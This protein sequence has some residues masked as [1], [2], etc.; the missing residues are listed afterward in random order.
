MVAV[1]A[2]TTPLFCNQKDAFRWW[3]LMIKILDRKFESVAGQFFNLIYC[4]LRFPYGIQF[5]KICNRSISH[6]PVRI[7]HTF[8]AKYAIE[9]LAPEGE[10]DYSAPVFQI[11][12][13]PVHRRCSGVERL[14]QSTLIPRVWQ[15]MERLKI[16]LL[17]SLCEGKWS[18]IEGGMQEVK[19]VQTK[20]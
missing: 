12:P 2:V 20:G 13:L 7:R 4:I 17:N 5:C 11:A 16:W 6:P 3:T 14:S 18:G 9:A 8:S 15:K 19:E 1:K 10:D